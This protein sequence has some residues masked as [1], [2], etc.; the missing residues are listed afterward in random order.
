MWVCTVC[1]FIVMKEHVTQCNNVAHW[2]VINSFWTIMELCGSE[3]E[4]I[5]GCDTSTILVRYIHCWF[6]CFIGICW[7]SEKYSKSPDLFFTLLQDCLQSILYLLK[8][9]DAFFP[10]RSFQSFSTVQKSTY[11]DLKRPQP[12]S[13]TKLLF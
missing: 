5:S 9:L 2:C 7:Q 10:P 11:R 3:E 6:W 12:T 8:L 13:C 1:V 4:D